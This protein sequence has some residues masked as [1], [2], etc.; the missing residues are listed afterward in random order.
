MNDD[1]QRR[2][3]EVRLQDLLNLQVRIN[4][5]AK[6]PKYEK[7]TANIN[8]IK[9]L[10]EFDTELA[11]KNYSKYTRLG[12]VNFVSKFIRFLNSKSLSSVSR[13]DILDF[14]SYLRKEGISET[15]IHT[16]SIRITAFLKWLQH[17]KEPKFLE[18]LKPKKIHKTKSFSDIPTE[19][20]VKKMIEVM[21]NPRDKAIVSVLYES[22][23]RISEFLNMK[24]RDLETTDYGFKLT[25]DGKTGKRPIFLINSASYLRIWLNHHPLKNDDNAYLWIDIFRDR[26]SEYGRLLTHT[27]IWRILIKAQRR[28]N[29][30]KHI[31]PHILR[32]SRLTELAKKLP[33][34]M[35]RQFAG[36]SRDSKMASVYVHLNGK[37]VEDALLSKVYGKKPVEEQISE[38]LKPLICNRCNTENPTEAKYCYKCY[39]PLDEKLRYDLELVKNVIGQVL[40]EA[41]KQPNPKE[42]LTEIVERFKATV[43]K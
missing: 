10:V 34:S 15:S 29:M 21:D 9:K 40:L 3:I 28:A 37:D 42:A 4:G 32:H 31:H 5:K 36:W 23:C 13:Q 11:N 16:I 22:G 7:I 14:Y 38:T 39:N 19:D 30:T 17:G 2:N 33:E 25:V 27:A 12:Y 24:V 20:E 8:S 41:W 43:N 1:L 26:Q 35:L 6:E 18:G